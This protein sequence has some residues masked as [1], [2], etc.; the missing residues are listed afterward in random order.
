MNK[1]FLLPLFV[2]L[3]FGVLFKT[4]L[5]GD[6]CLEQKK[7]CTVVTQAGLTN[8]SDI[9]IA[10]TLPVEAN[11]TLGGTETIANFEIK[12]V[13]AYTNTT[14]Y[15][16]YYNPALIGQWMTVGKMEGLKTSGAYQ[17]T[18]RMNYEKKP[19]PWSDSST[20]Y[21]RTGRVSGVTVVSPVVIWNITDHMDA[22]QLYYDVVVQRRNDGVTVKKLTVF[23]VNTARITGLKEK[24]DYRVTVRA[25]NSL[26]GLGR[27][28]LAKKFSI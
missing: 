7:P 10:V 5:A 19:S 22:A 18:A 16:G 8:R 25:Y 14:V 20:V 26:N 17:V 11:P 28:S 15:D 12:I 24:T 23:D 27:K 4:A 21:T 6:T 3:T 9:N 1:L 13:D 2:I